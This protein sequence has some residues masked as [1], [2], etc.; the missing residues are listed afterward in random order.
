[1][2]NELVARAAAESRSITGRS[3]S[4]PQRGGTL[5]C[6]S[7]HGLGQPAVRR[8][9]QSPQTGFGTGWPALGRGPVCFDTC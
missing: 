1:M 6:P 7:D 2:R 3:R 8:T 4:A 9:R 5:P